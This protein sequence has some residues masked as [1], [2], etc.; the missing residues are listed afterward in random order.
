M[1]DKTKHFPEQPA[2]EIQT[3][4]GTNIELHSEGAWLIVTEDDLIQMIRLAF[5]APNFTMDHLIDAV[6][7]VTES[8]DL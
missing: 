8:E 3:G 4:E 7:A 1:S 6:C 2:F 5:N